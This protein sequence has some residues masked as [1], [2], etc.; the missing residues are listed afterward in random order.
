MSEEASSN[1]NGNNEYN[2]YTP[3]YPFKKDRFII[4]IKNLELIGNKQI[5]IKLSVWNLK[6]N[7]KKEFFTTY[8]DT[9][10]VVNCAMKQL[11]KYL[12][13]N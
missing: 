10:D 11:M 9:G 5:P 4:D 6:L 13:N 7:E 2:I 8:N 3:H 1:P 12:K